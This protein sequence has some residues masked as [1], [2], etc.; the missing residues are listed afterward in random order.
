M[1]RILYMIDTS[2][3]MVVSQVGNEYAWPVLDFE[4][5]RPENNFETRYDL[6]KLTFPM[7]MP[8]LPY[9]ARTRKIPLEIKNFHRRFWGMKPLTNRISGR[10]K[11]KGGDRVKSR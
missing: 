2:T 4:H 11:H 6:E 8:G 3:G 9:C 7:A 1:K 5:M 10:C